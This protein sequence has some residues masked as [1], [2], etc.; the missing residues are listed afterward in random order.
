VG[1]CPACREHDRVDP[2]VSALLRDLGLDATVVCSWCGERLRLD[3]AGRL[4]VVHP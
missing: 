4:T 2:D 1:P 3:D